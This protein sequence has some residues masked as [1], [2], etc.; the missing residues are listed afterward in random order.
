ML[1]QIQA[2]LKKAMLE[3]NTMHVQVLRMVVSAL[4]NESIAKGLG[5]QGE[6]PPLE[7][8]AVVKRL[9]K[10]RQDSIDQFK[11]VGQHERAAVEQEEIDMLQI[12]LPKQMSEGELRQ[13]IQIAITATQAQN[14][15]DL[16]K[17]MKYLQ[18]EYAGN[19]D[20]KLASSLVAQLLAS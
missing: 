12:Y 4:R 5:P 13:A 17:V 18:S 14:A 2:D 7:S 8:L 10:S 3:K 20:G 19:Y 9:V 6:L 16:G 11:S 15:K 1:N